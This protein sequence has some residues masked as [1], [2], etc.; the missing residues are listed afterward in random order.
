MADSEKYHF[1]EIMGGF[2]LEGNTVETSRDIAARIVRDLGA[3]GYERAGGVF[4]GQRFG[5][6]SDAKVIAKELAILRAN[7]DL[8]T[9]DFVVGPH[10]FGVDD[11]NGPTYY[12]RGAM[13]FV[14][15]RATPAVSTE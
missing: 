14:R 4:P 3:R 11:E 7:Y 6:Y 12:P 13:L 15:P 1:A 5:Q 9:T 2:D 10:V 8:D